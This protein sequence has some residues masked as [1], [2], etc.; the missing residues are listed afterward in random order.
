[1]GRINYSKW[2][3]DQIWFVGLGEDPSLLKG[4]YIASKTKSLNLE[5]VHIETHEIA[6]ISMHIT[7][8]AVHR[9][10]TST[11][12]TLLVHFCIRHASTFATH[13]VHRGRM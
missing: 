10:T 12:I 8:Y 7:V 4:I 3:V 5:L 9:V 13:E 6:A 11:Y 2:Q 1:L